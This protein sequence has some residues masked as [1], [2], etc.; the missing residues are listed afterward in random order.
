MDIRSY[1]I[2]CLIIII[3]I[4]IFII[5]INPT[6]FTVFLNNFRYEDLN[7]KIFL[8]YFR[9]NLKNKNEIQKEQEDAEKIFTNTSDRVENMKMKDVEENLRVLIFDKS[10]DITTD[11]LIKNFNNSMERGNNPFVLFIYNQNPKFIQIQENSNLSY[12]SNIIYDLWS[13]QIENENIF[14]REE[15]NLFKN[16]TIAV[17][18]NKSN[19]IDNIYPLAFRYRETKFETDFTNSKLY[20]CKLPF[21]M[22]NVKFNDKI[23]YTIISGHYISIC[24]NE[25]DKS[26][27]YMLKQFFNTICILLLKPNYF[28]CNI[29]LTG[30][31]LTD[32]HRNILNKSLLNNYVKYNITQLHEN[33]FSLYIVDKRMIFSNTIKESFEKFQFSSALS[34]KYLL[35]DQFIVNSE[36]IETSFNVLENTTL[37]I[38]LTENLKLDDVIYDFGF[39]EKYLFSHNNQK[40]DDERGDENYKTIYPPLHDSNYHND[41]AE[42]FDMKDLNVHR[43]TRSIEILSNKPYQPSQPYQ[44][45]QPSEPIHSEKENEEK[46]E[47]EKE[48]KENNNGFNNIKC[49]IKNA[50]N[51]LWKNPYYK[52]SK[53][54]EKIEHMPTAPQ[55]QD[56][57]SLKVENTDSDNVSISSSTNKGYN[58]NENEFIDDDIIQN[59]N[60]NNN[61]DND[62]H[63]NN[64]D[65]NTYYTL[66]MT[67]LVRST[68]DSSLFSIPSILEESYQSLYKTNKSTSDLHSIDNNCMD[69]STK[70]VRTVQTDDELKGNS[71]VDNDIIKKCKIEFENKDLVLIDDKKSRFYLN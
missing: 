33:S 71:T 49:I 45:Y 64:T 58:E 26:D 4:L 63:N 16:V 43:P 9:N 3:S 18:K 21:L 61:H 66:G 59:N 8:H 2:I 36:R 32:I 51:S 54:I 38:N 22:L 35:I 44:P 69:K 55:F 7:P 48:K 15:N 24:M 41:D 28:I 37:I 46:I 70:I 13:I 67:K 25:N 68:S 30:F 52:L 14:S 57:I 10:V 11:M 20:S 27:L 17:N 62:H 5:I 40:D 1:V 60:N 23:N 6:N 42:V 31:E 29:L 39:I 19:K 12:E 65:I 47:N 34:E 53:D 50:K 56:I